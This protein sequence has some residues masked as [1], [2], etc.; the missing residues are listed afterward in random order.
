MKR[1][2]ATSLI[3]V[4]SLLLASCGVVGTGKSASPP[5]GGINVLAGDSRVTVSW[6]AESNVQYW[7]T[8]ATNANAVTSKSSNSFPG[9][10]IL[11]SVSSP[12]VIPALVNGTTYYFT[13]DARISGG[14]GG[15]DTP[16]VSATPHYAGVAPMPWNSGA[17]LGA[18]E[19]RG[20]TFGT[21]VGTPVG[22]H[23]VAVGA[24]GAMFSSADG[25]AWNPLNSV[26]ASDLNAVLFNT[27][28][29]VAVGAGGVILGST[30]GLN[31][32]IETSKTTNNLKGLTS[33]GAGVFIA[34]GANGTIV[35]YTSAAGGTVLSSATSNNLNAVTYYGGRMVAVGAGGII[36]T[37]A[38][39]INWTAVA[40]GTTQDLNGVS[41]GAG[42]YVAVGATGT[43]LTS[44][45]GLTWTV[46]PAITPNNLAAVTMGSQFVAIASGGGIFTS[47]DGITWTAQTS[48]TTNDLKAV[49][50]GNGGYSIVGAAGTNLT[51]Y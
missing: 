36:L 39:G 12:L 16:V 34:V 30:D 1:F 17:A 18:N 2:A 27:S 37:S 11:M 47:P 4:V 32:Q 14:P 24:G 5:A 7:L 42:L 49:A 44:P 43:V 29:Y 19:L 33:N 3:I 48:G 15:A 35:S 20:T 10:G 21:S 40:S 46:R 25:I 9:G 41:F 23:V 51:A 6:V 8:Y 28:T 22:I 13:M 31:W 26:V 38:D 50:S 45:D